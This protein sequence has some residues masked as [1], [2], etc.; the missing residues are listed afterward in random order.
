MSQM[1]TLPFGEFPQKV[2][3]VVYVDYSKL[4]HIT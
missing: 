3:A 4:T 1:Q 2:I